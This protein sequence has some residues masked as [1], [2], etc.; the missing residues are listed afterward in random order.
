MVTGDAGRSYLTRVAEWSNASG[1]SS[2]PSGSWVRLPPR[3]LFFFVDV[4]QCDIGIPRGSHNY[5]PLS[6]VQ[7]RASSIS[8]LS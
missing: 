5:T 1:S 6:A 7:A 8:K 4:D 3:V 2:G